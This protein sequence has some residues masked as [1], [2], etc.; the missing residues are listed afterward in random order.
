MNDLIRFFVICRWS[1][2]ALILGIGVMVC[3]YAFDLDIYESTQVFLEE[4]DHFE[5]DELM[6]VAVPLVFGIIF[7]LMRSRNI[8]QQHVLVV[9]QHLETLGSTLHTAQDI[10]NNFLNSIQLYVLKAHDQKL[11]SDDIER[12]DELITST[13]QR[14]NELEKPLLDHDAASPQTSRK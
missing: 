11:E 2:L 10:I 5:I 7:D 9:E 4:M 13:T 14:L 12:L 1:C 8:R 3:S 6:I